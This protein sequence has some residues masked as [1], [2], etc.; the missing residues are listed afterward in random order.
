MGCLT[1]ILICNNCIGFVQY[2][3][4]SRS[5]D[6]FIGFYGT[7]G[8]GLHTLSLINFMIAVYYFFTYQSNKK[9]KINLVLFLFFMLSAISCFYGLGLIVFVLTIC[10]Y[11]LSIKNFITTTIISV[12][13]V[14]LIVCFFYLF[15]Y[16][17][18]VY[19][20]NNI[21]KGELF[22]DKNIDPKFVDQIPR[23]LILYKNY[24]QVYTKDIGLF[25]LGSGPG[26]FN[27]RTYF[28]LNGDYSRT[29]FLESIL[30][31]H[32][33]KY[34]AKYVHTLWNSKNYSH[35]YF[36]DGTRNE[37]FSSVISML[38]EYGFIVSTLI[39]A[40]TYL[41]YRSLIKRIK[42]SLSFKLHEP[43]PYHNYLKF[44]SIFLFLNLFTDN[45]LEY[46]EIIIFY[47]LIYKLIELK[48]TDESQ[49]S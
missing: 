18:F 22:F 32:E 45:F 43:F 3:L 24:I 8:L 17:T 15:N 5:D 46:P 41:N 23:K 14:L 47:L 29:K 16:K 31:V 6:S 7:Q 40:L 44:I 37:P 4:N 49:E 11:N 20:Y 35:K 25:L 26:T 10:I 33:P 21:K 42:Y 9:K 27:S 39:L 12:L 2:A 38:A 30:G 28:L 36:T 19:N 1:V 48:T 13:V 34:A